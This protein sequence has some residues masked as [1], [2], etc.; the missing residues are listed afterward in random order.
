MCFLVLMTGL[1][2]TGKSRASEKLAESL[3]YNLICQN[4]VRR[5]FGMKKMPMRNGLEHQGPVLREVDKRIF[6]SLNKG[7]GIIVDASHRFEIRRQQIHGIASA[8]GKDVL[9]VEAKCSE[10]EA[11]KRM[12]ARDKSDG[13]VVDANKTSVYDRHKEQWEDLE[14]AFTD[15]SVMSH[16]SHIVFDSEKNEIERKEINDSAKEFVGKVEEILSGRN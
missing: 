8:L 14:K 12:R 16:V 11:K 2:G 10:E 9:I 7:Q 15:V 5:D 6:Y 1:P 13:L 3:G 4:D